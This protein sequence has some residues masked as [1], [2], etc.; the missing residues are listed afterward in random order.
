MIRTEESCAALCVPFTYQARSDC[1][2]RTGAPA[3]LP[4]LLAKLKEAGISDYSIFRRGQEL[5]LVMQVEDFDGAWQ[6]LDADP[7]NRKW[8]Q[9]MAPLFEPMEQLEP[10]ERFP[11]FREVF[12]LK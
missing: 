6:M 8:Q 10:G 7:V 5:L 9:F 1:H 11:M 2:L 4:E 12:Y 3:G